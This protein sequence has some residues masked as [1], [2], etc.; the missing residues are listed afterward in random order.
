MGAPRAAGKERNRK[1]AESKRV[2]ERACPERSEGNL[3]WLRS[4]TSCQAY[5]AGVCWPPFVVVVAVLGDN[6]LC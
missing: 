5:V 1:H 3:L 4:A 2:A 6:G